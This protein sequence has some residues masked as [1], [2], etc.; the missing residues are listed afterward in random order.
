MPQPVASRR[1]AALE[2]HLG[3]QL[4]DRSTRAVAPT[5]FGRDVLPMARRLVEVADALLQQA[6][7]AW[8]RPLGLAVPDTCSQEN[9]V[10]L[11]AE[12]YEQQ[13][14]LH[15]HSTGP[16]ERAQMAQT[17]DVRVAVV[18]T[19]ADEAVWQVPLGLAS[20]A[21]AAAEA[22]YLDTLRMG[23]LDGD[24]PARRVWL[25]PEDDVPH[26]RDRLTALGD[27][28]GLQPSQIVVAG[29]V[30]AAAARVLTS[31][32]LL[33]CSPEQARE[34]HL[35]WA[36]LGETNLHRG[37]RLAGAEPEDVSRVGALLGA[38]IGTCLGAVATGPAMR[39]SYHARRGRT[40]DAEPRGGASSTTGG[41]R[42][43][44]RRGGLR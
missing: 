39:P 7:S 2:Q 35:P 4:L 34:L 3:G 25:Q 28:V 37:Y 26:V 1:I 19:P 24:R 5:A 12:A 13:L 32:D 14:T 18:A 43:T 20:G 33:L 31:Q 11:V 15:L 8:L 41:A 21:P 23:R 40:P 9:L 36:R 10:R 6:G 42:S 17:R 16:D 38:G 44:K 29:S 27:A 30:V 22:L